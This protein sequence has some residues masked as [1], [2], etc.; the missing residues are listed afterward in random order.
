MPPPLPYVALGDSTAVGVGARH[1]GY[2]ERLLRRLEKS[3]PV[4]LTNLGQSGATSSDVLRAQL[5]R[6]RGLDARL[7]TLGV[8]VND[9]WRMVPSDVFQAN[10]Q[11]MARVL[12]ALPARVF[13]NNLPDLSHAPVGQLAQQLLGVTPAQ[14]GAHIAERN[15]AFDVFAPYSNI[16]VF[17]THAISEAALRGRRDFFSA[18]GFHPSDAGYERWA[19]LLWREMAQ[20]G[21]PHDL[22][23]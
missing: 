4:R 13:V 17:D 18:D 14:L 1:G 2:P 3:R 20:A 8:G 5:P 6:L 16:T 12:G 9:L 7:V 22:A 10:L 15:R 19:R 11:A 21:V 23:A